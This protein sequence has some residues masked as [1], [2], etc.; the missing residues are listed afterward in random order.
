MQPITYRFS[1][2]TGTDLAGEAVYGR[3]RRV[4][5]R[6]IRLRGDRTFRRIFTLETMGARPGDWRHVA[7]Y[8]EGAYSDTATRYTFSQG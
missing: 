8:S 1:E 2:R 5:V 3:P 7:N 6:Y 4:T